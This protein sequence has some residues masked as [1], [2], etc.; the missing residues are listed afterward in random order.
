MHPLQNANRQLKMNAVEH[1]QFASGVRTEALPLPVN[2]INLTSAEG[3]Q[4]FLE[5]SALRSYLPLANN[6]VTQEKLTYCGVAS[7]V[8]VL[9]A[10]QVPAPACTQFGSYRTFT[11]DNLL[12]ERTDAVVPRD[13]IAWKG[14][15]LDQ[16]GE[17]LSLF[18]VHVEVHHAATASLQEFRDLACVYLGQPDH[19]VIVNYLRQTIGQ[20]RGGHVSPLAA[21]DRKTDRFLILDVAR[22]K[23]PPVWVEAAELFNAM[24]TPDASNKYR[25]RGFVL[26]S[27]RAY[28]L[29]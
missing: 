9:N 23:Y 24:N 15:T 20:E 5:S 6:F 13:T 22:Y 1:D 21:Y 18:P 16:V 12:N 17:I 3:M 2:L 29:H 10:L 19:A 11:Q 8:M 27:R 4:L 28:R 25:T 26:I 14:M 7:T